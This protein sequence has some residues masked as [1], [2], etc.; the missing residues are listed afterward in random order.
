MCGAGAMMAGTVA[1]V[2]LAR[3][4]RRLC[5]GSTHRVS[6]SDWCAAPAAGFEDTIAAVKKSTA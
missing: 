5:R 4:C 6:D 3:W 2:A 1:T